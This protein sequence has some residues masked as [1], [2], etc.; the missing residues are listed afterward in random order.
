[1]HRYCL[2]DRPLTRVRTWYYERRS[3]T[4]LRIRLRHGE[5]RRSW[6]K[7]VSS[8]NWRGE[9][10]W[11]WTQPTLISSRR[12]PSR[13]ASSAGTK[14]MSPGAADK[15]SA[16]Q[17][18]KAQ[19]PARQA[20][21]R[22]GTGAALSLQSGEQTQVSLE[23]MQ[24]LREEGREKREQEQH[25]A[26]GRCFCKRDLRRAAASRRASRRCGRSA[27]ATTSPRT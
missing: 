10:C 1:M 20:P 11:R 26:E 19:V 2:Q 21:H 12:W 16:R 9:R 8:G 6:R 14:D 27:A 4:N 7:T 25:K 24:R 18:S 23:T 15:L 5:Q 17:T 13:A 22:A 3:T